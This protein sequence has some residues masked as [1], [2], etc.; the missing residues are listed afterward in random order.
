MYSEKIQ[1]KLEAE[2]IEVGDRIKVNDHKGTLMPKTKASRKGTIVL[3]LESGYN[4]GL[5]PEE[6]QL[7]QKQ[8]G[9]ET[10]QTETEYDEEKPNI[11]ILH[12]GG[13]IAS[14][15]SYEEGGVKPAFEPEE[16]IKMYPGVADIANIHSEVVAQM[17]SEDMEPEHWQEIA[18][19][20]HEV[21]NDYDGIII[22]H[23]TDTM[24]YTGAAL[25]LMLQN[26]DTGVL[27]VGAQRSSDRPST[28][29]AT[30]M[31][32]AT[33]LLTET[34]YTGLGI[35]MHQTSNDKE[36][37]VIPAAKARKMHTSRRDAFEPVNT[38]PEARINT[39]TGKIKYSKSNEAN[40]EYKLETELNTNI[41]YLKVRPGLT[42]EEVERI[43]EH[44]YSGLIIEG[45]GLGHMPVNSFDDKTQ[46]HKEILQTIEKIAEE[47]LVI[48]TSQCI[49]GRIN[50]N[51][52]DAGY[53]IQE[54]G[55]ISGED[56]HPELAYVKLM[57]SLG[58][59]KSL[60]KAKER[61][62]ENI[63]GEKNTRTPYTG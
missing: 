55:V 54:A 39:Q 43:L 21:K 59:T 57:W 11:L 33:K 12:T 14:K 36:C 38:Q 2:N 10:K 7:L 18:Q 27:L 35:C 26:I 51:V 23:G 20:I 50:M 29:A 56:M 8:Q 16:L 62:R 9:K 15:V 1:K 17:L 58:T 40:G 28:D 13:T 48:M 24:S 25:S 31:Y 61:F 3:K 37:Y 47:T 49:N 4:I 22:G 46:H 42:V 19:K 53:K 34:D 30:N 44:D 52:Y 32:A 45:T 41:G 63:S 5:E 6:I 60:E